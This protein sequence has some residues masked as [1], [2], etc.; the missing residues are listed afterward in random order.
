MPPGWARAVSPYGASRSQG[1]SGRFSGTSRALGRERGH[2]RV[3]PRDDADL[4][5]AAGG[6]DLFEELDVG[7]VVVGPLLGQVIFVV[8]RLNGADRLAGTAVDALVG[9]DVEHAV[10]LVDAVDGAL[11]DA[12]AVLEVDA[13]LGDDVGHWIEDPFAVW[14]TGNSPGAEA[15]PRAPRA[16]ACYSAAAST[17]VTV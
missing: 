7:L 1:K 13:G 11:V 2:D 8:D 9:L 4:R 15:R 16:S 12:G 3:V 14:A 10:A 6:S 17:V 5:G